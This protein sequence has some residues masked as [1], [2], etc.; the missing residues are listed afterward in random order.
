MEMKK[1]FTFICLLLCSILCLFA[2]NNDPYKNMKLEVYHDNKIVTENDVINLN[3]KDEGSGVYSYDE[4]TLLVKVQ[5]DNDET[6][7]QISIG[8]GQGFV[9]TSSEFDPITGTTSISVKACSV[10]NT[11]KVALRIATN[12]GNKSILIHFN[13]DL[14]LE[15]FEFKEN[16][17]DVVGKGASVSLANID[18]FIT[19]TPSNTTQKDLTL[20][21]AS[22]EVAGDGVTYFVDGWTEGGNFSYQEDG[23]RYA[24]LVDGVLTTYDTYDNGSGDKTKIK[25]PIWVKSSSMGGDPIQQEVIIIKASYYF[26]DSNE[27]IS[28]FL[29]I[30]VV[31]SCSEISVNMNAQSGDSAEFELPQ[32]ANGE[33]E[34]VL[35]DPKYENDIFNASVEYYIERELNFYLSDD[36]HIE[37][38]STDD[39]NAVQLVPITGEDHFKVHAMKAG[40]YRHEF[41]IVHNEYPDLFD[42]K[43]VIEFTVKDLPTDILIN[44]SK[45]SQIFTIYDY[46]ANSAKGTK[47]DV[48][49]NTKVGQYEYSVYT[50]NYEGILNVNLNSARSTENL[51]FANIIDNKI[52]TTVEG[53]PYTKF[54]AT[55]S[56]YLSHSFET[57]PST[58]VSLSIGVQIS[59]C[60]DSYY[61]G[62]SEEELN[63]MFKILLMTKS[64]VVSFQMGLRSFDF[65]SEKL[66]IDLTNTN[67][68]DGADPT[69]GKLICTLPEGQSIE[70]AIAK[71]EYDSSLVTIVEYTPAERNART[72]LY[73]QCN[74]NRLE[75]STLLKLTANNGVTGE[76]GITTYMPT[77]YT[78]YSAENKIPLAIS[79]DEK[80]GGYLYSVSGSSTGAVSDDDIYADYISHKDPFMML[81]GMGEYLGSYDSLHT[82]FGLIDGKITLKFYDYTYI[83]GAFEPYNISS[84]IAIYFN[85]DGYINYSYDKS[86]DSIVLNLRRLA[87]D[88]KDPIVMTIKYTGGYEATDEGESLVYKEVTLEHKV[89]VYVYSP[90]QGVN[91]LSEKSSNLYVYDSLSYFDRTTPEIG[92][93]ATRNLSTNTIKASFSPAEETLG[94]IW[95]DFFGSNPDDDTVGYKPLLLWYECK[96][97]DEAVKDKNDKGVIIQSNIAGND[98][99][100]TYGDLFQ[101]TPVMVNDS[102]YST[103][104]TCRL[105]EE[106]LAWIEEY[107]GGVTTLNNK[108]QSFLNN[109]ILDKDYTMIVN[110][111]ASQFGK[112][113]NVNT[114]SY[115]CSYATKINSLKLNIDDDGVYFDIRDIKEQVNNGKI[116]TVIEYT[117]DNAKCINKEMIIVGGTTNHFDTTI[118]YGSGN[119]GK[120]IVTPVSG[121]LSGAVY[122]L[123]IILKDNVSDYSLED[124]Y[125]YYNNSLNQTIRV[126]VADGSSAFAF[127]IRTASE[128]KE[129]LNDIKNA[130]ES[131]VKET[132]YMYYHYVIARENINLSGVVLETLDITR[133]DRGVFSLSGKHIYNYNGESVCIYGKIYNLTIARK[134]SNLNENINIGLFGEIGSSAKFDNVSLLNT[135]I[136]VSASSTFVTNKI[137]SAGILAG[138][139]SNATISNIVVSGSIKVNINMQNGELNVGGVVGYGSGS[140]SGKPEYA[141]SGVS[142]TGNNAKV[143]IDITGGSYYTLQV[144]GI[145]GLTSSNTSIQMM[146]I[147]S[148]INVKAQAQF[149]RIGGVVGRNN[150]RTTTIGGLQVS[151]VISVEKSSVYL[152]DVGGMIGYMHG[153]TIS[154]SKVYFVNIGDGYSQKDKVNIYVSATL[155]KDMSD[156]YWGTMHIGGLVGTLACGT[157]RYSYARSFYNSEIKSGS[158]MGN[159]Y[160][161]E[162]GKNYDNIFVGGI[163]GSLGTQVSEETNLISSYFDG[164]IMVSSYSQTIIEDGNTDINYDCAMIGLITGSSLSNK[165]NNLYI[166]GSYAIGNI[167]YNMTCETIDMR[168]ESET[169]S[170]ENKFVPKTDVDSYNALFGSFYYNNA[171]KSEDDLLGKL[172]N[173]IDFAGSATVENVYGVANNTYLYFMEEGTK[174]VSVDSMQTIIDNGVANNT[175]ALFKN[176]LN[177]NLTNGSAEGSLTASNYRWFYNDK[178]NTAGGY[179]YPI[180]LSSTGLAMYDLV[181]TEIDIIINSEKDSIF[182]LSYVD[183]KANKHNQMVMFV[184]KTNDGLYSNDYYEIMVE[185]ETGSDNA[186]IKVVFNGEDI[187]TDLVTINIDDNIEILLKDNDGVLELSS[188]RIYPKK[189]GQATIEI[190]SYLD[191]TIKTSIAVKVIASV[192]TIKM[193]EIVG[194]NKVEVNREITGRDVEHGVVYIDETSNFEI[195]AKDSEN[196]DSTENIGYIL[197]LLSEEDSEKNGSIIIDGQKYSYN[198]E[199]NNTY[200]IDATNVLKASGEK[201]GYVRFKLT[202][203]L[204]LG[205]MYYEDTYTSQDGSEIKFSGTLNENVYI[206]NKAGKLDISSEYVLV[207]MAR[208][209]SVNNSVKVAEITSK[210]EFEVISTIETSNVLISVNEEDGKTTYTLLEDVYVDMSLYT[211]KIDYTSL[212]QIRLE[213]ISWEVSSSDETYYFNNPYK[214]EYELLNMKVTGFTIM[215]TNIN[216]ETRLNTYKVSIIM[217]VLFDKEFYRENASKYD[218]NTVKFNINII[219]YSNLLLDSA[220]ENAPYGLKNDQIIGTTVVNIAPAGLTDIFMNYYSRGEGLLSNT[221]NTYPSDNESNFIVPNRDGLLK[222]TLAEEFNNSSYVT[223]TLDKKFSGYV[224]LEQMAGVLQSVDSGNSSEFDTYQE[225]D[226]YDPVETSEYFGIRLQKLTSNSNNKT[227]FNNTYFVKVTLSDTYS[228]EIYNSPSYSGELLTI[229][230]SVT[231]YTIASNGSV[232]ETLPEPKVKTLTIADLPSL[233][234]EVDNASVLNMGIGVKK[235]MS[236]RYRG[237]TNDIIVNSSSSYLFV[238]D[239]SGESVAS[240][241]I[242]Y[243]DNGGKYYLCLAVDAYDELDTAGTYTLTLSAEEYVWGMLE[244][245]NSQL[246]IS[247]VEFEITGVK[248]QDSYY[249]EETKE[250]E[251]IINH[252]QSV[253]LRLDF[254]YADIE[255]ALD[256]EI[257]GNGNNKKIAEHIARLET[258]YKYGRENE[259]F[260]PK[261]LVEYAIAGTTVTST[262]NGV[263]TELSRGILDLYRITYSGDNKELEPIST[264]GI[265][266]GIELLRDSYRSSYDSDNS[267]PVIEILYTLL[268]GVSISTDNLLR[269]SVPYYYENGRVVAGKSTSE[270]Y[271]DEY[272]EF[273]VI[274]KDN[275]SD[276]HPTPI[277]DQEDLLA[278]AG[279]SGHYILVNNITLQNWSPVPLS[280]DSLDG[281]G[282]VIKISSFDMSSIRSASDVNAGIF[283]TISENTLVKNLTIDIGDILTTEDVMLNDISTIK[284]ST[285]DRY[286]HDQ[287]GKIDL[288]F[289]SSLNFGILAGENNGSITNV[290]IVNT[291]NFNQSSSESRYL[292]IL[293]S[294]ID[295][296]GNATTSN[297]GGIVGVNSATGAISNSFVGVNISTE[298][299]VTLGDGSKETRHYIEVVT[300]PDTTEYHNRYDEMKEIQVFPF[301]LAG[302]NNVAGAV[303]TNNGIISNSYTKGLGIYNSY[304]AVGNSITAGLVGI[305]NNKVTSCFVEGNEIK[306]YRATGKYAGETDYRDTIEAV[307]S[308]GGLVYTNNSLIENSYANVYLTTQSSF[309]AGFVFTNN[310]TI[311][312]S[313]STSVNKNNWA[314]GPFTGVLNKTVQ[315]FG[316]YNN[317]YY[318]V[319]G[320]SETKNETEDAIPIYTKDFS[321]SVNTELSDFWKGFSFTSQSGANDEDGIWT[322]GDSLPRIA[323]TLIDTNSF[324]IL[325]QIEDVSGEDGIIEYQRYSYIYGT[326]YQEGSRGNPLVIES[327]ETFSEKLI[328]RGR[329]IK[330]N[331]KDE[332]VFGA[333]NSRDILDVISAVEYVRLVNNLDF[334]ADINKVDGRYLYE[335]IFAGKL[336]GNGMSMNNVHIDTDSTNPLENF[337]M[338]SQVGV[339]ASLASSITV[340]KNLNIT[341]SSF[342]G[343]GDSKAGVLAGTIKNAT[344]ANVNIDGNGVEIAATNMAGALAGLILADGQNKVSIVDVGVQNITVE[345]TNKSLGGEIDA[346]TQDQSKGKYKKFTIL[347]KENNERE[348]KEFKTLETELKDNVLNIKNTSQVS[349]AGAVAGVLIANNLDEI[350]SGSLDVNNY[351]SGS[352]PCSIDNVIV[353]GAITIKNADNS[354]GLF[355]YLSS[356]SRIKNCKFEMGSDAQLIKSWNFAG[357][358]VGE[359]YGVI[360]QCFV[361][362]DTKTQSEYDATMNEGENR[363]NGS[364]NLFYMSDGDFYNVAVGG[365]AGYSKGGAIVDSYSKASV[366]QPLA[367]IAGGLIGYADS[368]NYIGYSYSTGSVYAKVITGGIIGL[369]VSEE[370][371]S[372][373]IVYLD[374][375]VALNNWNTHRDDISKILYDNYKSLY[376]NGTGYDNFYLKMPEIGNQNIEQSDLSVSY[377]ASH[378]NQYVGSVIGASNIFDSN[379]YKSTSKDVTSIY[380]D[381]NVKSVFSTTYGILSSDTNGAIEDGNR[382]DTYFSETFDLE[383]GLDEAV[384]LYSYRVA[385]STSAI[386]SNSY[387][388]DSSTETGS[389]STNYLDKISFEKVFTSQEYVEQLLGAFYTYNED[390]DGM[391]KKT[392]N[393]FKGY[394]DDRYQ[395]A[396]ND[397]VFVDNA[398]GETSIWGMDDYLPEINDGTYVLVEYLYAGN[399]ADVTKL[400]S[401]LASSTNDKTYYL[402][403]G[404]E[405]GTSTDI[406]FT[407]DFADARDIVYLSAI[408]SAFIGQ[409]VSNTRPKIVFNLNNTI[410]TIFNLISGATF[411]NVDIVVNIPSSQSNDLSTTNKT[412]TAYGILANTLENVTLNN[413]SITL[414]YLNS[415]NPTFNAYY[416]GSKTYNAF[417]NGL[418]FGNISNSVIK[419]STFKILVNSNKIILN[420]SAIENFGVFAGST[421]RSYLLNNSFEITGSGSSDITIQ[422]DKVAQ[423]SNIGGLIGALKNSTY[424]HCGIK[425][426][427]GAPKTITI[428]DNYNSN[429]M[430]DDNEVARTKSVSSLFGSAY[431]SSINLTDRAVSL[432]DTM[433]VAYGNS[434]SEANLDIVNVGAIAGISQNTKY[435]GIDLSNYVVSTSTTALVSINA[436]SVANAQMSVGGLIGKDADSSQIGELVDDSTVGNSS[437]ISITAYSNLLSV[438]GLVGYTS[439]ATKI[440]NA[441]NMG[442]ITVTNTRQGSKTQKVDGNG[443]PVYSNGSPVYTYTYVN[444]YV[445][446]ILGSAMGRITMEAILSSGNLNVNGKPN[447]NETAGFGL[448]G[449]IGYMAYSSDLS[450]FTILCDFYFGSTFTSKVS[451][452]YVSGIVG[453]NKGSFGAKNG[454]VY[455][456]FRFDTTGNL[457][458]VVTSATT[459]NSITS[460]SN[461]FYAQEFVGNNYTTDSKFST[462]AMADVYDTISPYS[463]LTKLSGV[464]RMKISVYNSAEKNITTSN[465]R[466][467]IAVSL[468]D[469][470]EK[471][472]VVSNESTVSTGNTRFTM[473]A[474][475]SSVSTVDI[476]T[477]YKYVAI[478]VSGD[479]MTVSAITTLPKGN[480]IS[481][482]SISTGKSLITLN[483]S[484]SAVGTGYFVGTNNGVISNIYMRSSKKTINADDETIEELNVALVDTNNGLITDSYVYERTTSQFGLAE[485]NNGRIYK[486]AT[487]TIYLG[488]E[489]EIYGLVKINA[490]TISDCYSASVGYTENDSKTTDVYM[491][492]DNGVG[493]GENEVKGS[494][495]NSFYYIPDILDFDNVAK[496]VYK[497]HSTT[498]EGKTVDLTKQGTVTNVYNTKNPSF[499]SSRTSIWGTENEHGQINGI[500]DIAGAMV[501]HIYYASTMATG[502]VFTDIDSIATFKNNLFNYNYN[503][504]RSRFIYKVHFYESEAPKYNVVR[505]VKAS[506]LTDYINSLA[507]K[508]Y[509]I[510]TNTVVAIFND[511]TV[512]SDLLHS[513]SLSTRSMFIGLEN[514]DKDGNLNSRPVIDFGGKEMD[515]EFIKNNSGF[516]ANFILRRLSIVYNEQRASFAP[517][518]TNSTSAIIDN[519]QFGYDKA[520]ANDSIGIKIQAPLATI[521]SGLVAVNNGRVYNA[522]LYSLNIQSL[523]HYA[524]FICSNSVGTDTNYTV[525]LTYTNLS[526]S[527]KLYTTGNAY[528]G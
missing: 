47:I 237:L 495:I 520:G 110:V 149:A 511:I 34:M 46:Y 332:Y 275:S 266:G 94:M 485:T 349:Y 357:G 329:T 374:T 109:Y 239:E 207:I 426:S 50:N 262:V 202:P 13:I 41:R 356:N 200:L 1:K 30:P 21:M 242:E 518:L 107:Y 409:T 458:G 48:N 422:V 461:V 456:E 375:V 145:I 388:V 72:S 124:G 428:V 19:F 133:S 59:L 206:L 369:Q 402:M 431:N 256:T 368:L 40:V 77:I 352:D 372:Q 99:Y 222:I 315:N 400:K 325:D 253:I 97:L 438:G 212:K 416:N 281:N 370:N 31:E 213:G 299:T 324:R 189:E 513:F 381:S 22:L 417:N 118:E 496:G 311:S 475:T 175:W 305:N 290:K 79:V 185:R 67:Y 494:I 250:N 371:K 512:S 390:D 285:S 251:L 194:S 316:T 333:V 327:A 230:I 138:K 484:K 328:G 397:D 151:P 111:Y 304:P 318:L 308:V 442:T 493:S 268:R 161:E 229:D 249:N 113:R 394:D 522:K 277:E 198:A 159:I 295:K 480:Y 396:G 322:M 363:D 358:I 44:N 254:Q 225:L 217:S 17:L 418:L 362:Y 224:R 42:Q 197:E 196:Y 265:H 526:T 386:T 126:K 57:L 401:I 274:I 367:F 321:A 444:T 130:N 292:H 270:E 153:G 282:Y 32:N 43:V 6:D 515:H 452:A 423:T 346:F 378:S 294:Q 195:S 354:G 199:G 326:A 147:V 380:D 387:I 408:R 95:N 188:N 192:D 404:N 246:W 399:D 320:E 411:S 509:T 331:G 61:D 26:A 80:S 319:V 334:S 260:S 499:V 2:C 445:G 105:S 87:T 27:I 247:P 298:A 437:A 183:D 264:I 37:A 108:V 279:T 317:C 152:L 263:E 100:L 10:D 447:T 66:N 227:Y 244:T 448:G 477:S 182:D 395:I 15:N 272:I 86:S 123:K 314:Y 165:N 430:I 232:K 7:R 300:N 338:F 340:I 525:N 510:P 125:S 137:V 221:E 9:T 228:N 56:F 168:G 487:A 377:I 527:S 459:N 64:F 117:I 23:Q 344:I 517:I 114:I 219:P 220:N 171:V 302:S 179:A 136:T 463:N 131:P 203:Y 119:T 288:T 20:S 478:S 141:I 481:G 78:A 280:V 403:P 492:L 5:D 3:I 514:T 163:A 92:S 259:T 284:N 106:L 39:S 158:Y 339:D 210:N 483:Y 460:V 410:G 209:I 16:A 234:V 450:T 341:L 156:S 405:E 345:A 488:E 451:N 69:K 60:S 454:Y 28:R 162:L 98:Y 425:S 467:P 519:V 523:Y 441:Y 231:S 121:V 373:E 287:A 140:I 81:D 88:K 257:D 172:Y 289:V 75:G 446:G 45:S 53:K 215:K 468:G 132:K 490:G 337:G 103:T 135:S 184:K 18:N 102:I 474:Y 73:A 36:F 309:I 361:S 55:D 342:N 127:E 255:V 433:K 330:V 365:I 391:M 193:Y 155:T 76:I 436:P 359:N 85:N 439:K 240:L 84:K 143:E 177:Y 51:V 65:D 455:S 139:I 116:Q 312:N 223:V 157:V 464:T 273:R 457:A 187:V 148:N 174:L 112:L 303:V 348:E 261:Q 190:R 398:A 503:Y 38:D 384:S 412:Y 429:L 465:A 233:V 89:K 11:G 178:V 424:R 434:S 167:Y 350:T 129:M 479:G 120:I 347:N 415:A 504:S 63:S 29:M 186:T 166:T 310:G 508:D 245:T 24:S 498:Q 173:C 336:D 301:V 236:I 353:S 432:Y 393:V 406:E 154:N 169:S 524:I 364:V 226:Y 435:V 392:Y 258:Y 12:E 164:D 462:F 122:D 238:V 489:D 101:I 516:V 208:A 419:D 383:L 204:K 144:G 500:K 71:M 82:L 58:A 469:I 376:T 502:G 25:Y 142:S 296:D 506:D 443:N 4:V 181:P 160:A 96:M 201:L 421:Y 52:T 297:I 276:T 115:T 382:N 501:L 180:L 343:H 351:R 93:T 146:Q 323:T 8:D 440:Y 407:I 420:N 104:I 507:G 293:T 134:I 449:L 335:T 14:A 216:P 497:R 307:G 218:L 91:I 528:N 505:V 476:A 214:F 278:Y 379:G 521:V 470:V 62:Y 191:K 243:L 466:L 283:T 385:Y 205:D 291:K 235:E 54:N 269:M 413:V 33:Y 491:V 83:N 70:S 241:S 170:V 286:V 472:K 306:S 313:Y 427:T 74:K 360:E 414:N 68:L 90:L 482:R 453:L 267:N 150:E 366:I 473:K 252:G 248:L 355:G 35:I 271:Y 486:S 49:L 176:V 128:F 211:A 389:S 471:V